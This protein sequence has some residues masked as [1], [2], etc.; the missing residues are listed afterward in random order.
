M[1][2][3][4]FASAKPA[5]AGF[6]WAT[7]EDGTEVIAEYRA[8]AHSKNEKA[9]FRYESADPT[10]DKVPRALEVAVTA[11]RKA[12]REAVDEALRR[13]LTLSEQCKAAYAQWRESCRNWDG[14][15]QVELPERRRLRM[16]EK[17]KAG[18]LTDCEV[19]AVYEEGQAVAVQSTLVRSQTSV[20][21][22]DVWHW[23]HVERLEPPSPSS[24]SS[25]R[26]RHALS[27]SPA[28]VDSVLS[29]VVKWNVDDNPR[30]QRGYVWSLADKRRL[31]ASALA[32]RE[33]GKVVF[34]R[35]EYPLRP[36]ILDGKQ[37]LNTLLEFKAGQFDFQ[38]F[39]WD[40]LSFTDRTAIDEAPMLIADIHEEHVDEVFVL[41]TFLDLN[42][43]GVPQSE[44]HL[45][46]VQAQLAEALAN[47]ASRSA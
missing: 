37:R 23:T 36:Q 34:V 26:I 17:V 10:V 2:D 28:D 4:N 38:G 5:R 3:S 19:V 8:I 44:E 21:K 18:S 45:A 22:V 11:Y 31:I 16:G 6:Y 39:Y 35:R 33:L 9:W 42:A 47:A 27:F 20:R 40:Q 25:P 32:R 14:Y 43:A 29:R 15:R 1:A 24:F 7:L 13:E 46:A 30:Y 41:Q 12:S